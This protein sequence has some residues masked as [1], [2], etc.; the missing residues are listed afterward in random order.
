MKSLQ[1]HRTFNVEHRDLNGRGNELGLAQGGG[2]EFLKDFRGEA[3]H[4][5]GKK[6]PGAGT[7][8]PVRRVARLGVEEDVAIGKDGLKHDGRR[9]PR[10]LEDRRGRSADG[11]CSSPRSAFPSAVSGPFRVRW[12]LHA[13]ARPDQVRSE[14]RLR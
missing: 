12:R 9:D 2:N 14:A 13:P 5:A 6:F 4:E 1:E 11:H 7:L 8:L 10:D 3:G